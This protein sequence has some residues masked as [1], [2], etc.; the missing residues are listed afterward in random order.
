MYSN[1]CTII[2]PTKLFRNILQP[3]QRED[4]KIYYRLDYEVILSFGLT[5]LKAQIS[6]KENVGRFLPVNLKQTEINFVH[7]LH[8][9]KKNGK[10]LG[11]SRLSETT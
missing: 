10:F 7:Y 6:W 2:T 3:Q 9:E 4:G 8:R 11:F 5:E 1:L